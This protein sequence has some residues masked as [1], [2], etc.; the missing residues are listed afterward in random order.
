MRV[1]AAWRS[2][3]RCSGAK[4][5]ARQGRGARGTNGAGLLWRPHGQM[6]RLRRRAPT[7]RCMPAR[8]PAPSCR[9]AVLPGGAQG[10]GRRQ[11]PVQGPGGPAVPVSAAAA[12]RDG[13]RG[14][15]DNVGK[16]AAAA[17][18]LQRLELA[19][20][21]RSCAALHPSP[22]RLPPRP[23]ALPAARRACTPGCVSAWCASCASTPSGTG[24]RAAVHPPPALSCPACS[25]MHVVGLASAG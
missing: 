12:E 4:R 7:C 2:D 9:A 24:G 5:E 25:R 11:L 19:L 17:A 15:V 16:R 18:R 3:C 21:R 22:P 20:L 13:S 1:G 6:A 14:Q 23:P 10:E 8:L